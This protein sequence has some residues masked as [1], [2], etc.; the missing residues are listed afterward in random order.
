MS[1]IWRF[2]DLPLINCDIELDLKCTKTCVVSEISRTFRVV[3]SN[4]S[5]AVYQ[6][7]TATTGAAFQINNAKLYAPLVTLSI[8]DNIK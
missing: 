2:L 1:N 3:D 5:V 7:E 6:V 4:A 8:N